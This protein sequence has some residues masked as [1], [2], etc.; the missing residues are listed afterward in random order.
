VKPDFKTIGQST[1][2][3]IFWWLLAV[4]AASISGYPGVI[5]VTPMGWLLALPVGT[6]CVQISPSPDPT[7]RLLEAGLGGALLGFIQG[8][9]F[10]A[11]LVLASPL[12]FAESQ[13]ADTWARH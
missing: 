5:C 1:W 7:S 13:A 9:I 11:V 3:P 2:L 8:S 12:R 10:A 4:I 6:R